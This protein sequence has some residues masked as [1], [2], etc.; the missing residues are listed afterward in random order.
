M[1]TVITIWPLCLK[2]KMPKGKRCAKAMFACAMC[3]VQYTQTA[4]AHSNFVQQYSCASKS[5]ITPVYLESIREQKLNMWDF[6]TT[7]SKMK[8]IYWCMCIP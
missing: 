5:T 1:K 8:H 2:R 7:V 4:A 3:S 6:P